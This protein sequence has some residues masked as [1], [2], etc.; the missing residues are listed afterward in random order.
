MAIPQYRSAEIADVD[1]GVLPAAIP[2]SDNVLNVL[3]QVRRG[4]GN[5]DLDDLADSILKK[6]QRVRGLVVARKE[7]AARKYLNEVNELWGTTLRLRDV[8]KCAIDSEEFYLFLAYGH[9]RYQACQRASARLQAGETS[10]SFDGRFRCNI[11][12]TM[13]FREVFPVQLLENMYVPPP[14]DEE[15]AAMWRYW[16][17][18][19]KYEPG[20]TIAGF[21]RHIGRSPQVV[22][23]MLQFC[24]LPELVQ[25]KVRPDAPGGRASFS[26]LLEVARLYEAQ[27]AY[28]KP[29]SDL[30]VIR[31]TD[32]HVVNR[33][34]VSDLAKEV[35][36]RIKH[37]RGGQ[38]DLFGTPEPIEHRVIRKVAAGNMIG[39]LSDF[40]RWLNVIH[41]MM[42]DGESFGGLSP[43][44]VDA[45]TG[46][47]GTTSPH[48]VASV[49]V[50]FVS[51]LKN[52][53]PDIAEMI[54]RDGRSATRL[55]AALYDLGIEEVVLRALIE[56]D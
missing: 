35:T 28:K 30:E 15:V 40:L 32:Y 10:T 50:R 23:N 12:F 51:E 44:V 25:R 53:V 4:M 56:R 27:A 45:S 39:G 37:L 48:S 47:R 43:Y 18:L 7:R 54:R 42:R 29:M 36:L 41:D 14:K 9:R 8:R 6:G 16:R 19:Q 38:E 49:A 5:G 46:E 34:R 55:Q 22:R 3:P 21:A 20:M 2:V 1:D 33:T 26:L 11:H 24:S 31:F 17:F 52:A 13:N